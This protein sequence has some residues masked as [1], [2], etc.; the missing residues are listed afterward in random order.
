MTL[1][2]SILKH[3][4]FVAKPYPDPLHGWAV[5]TFGHG[6]TFI[7]EAESKAIVAN[8]IYTSK[9]ALANAYGFFVQLPEGVQ[10]VLVEMAYQMGVNGVLSFKNMWQALK[11]RDLNAAAT[12]M[13]DSK[14]HQQT[15]KRAQTLADKMRSHQ[16]TIGGLS[17]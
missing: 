17:E 14:W 11:Q 10:D 1:L 7:T 16:A 2:E 12:A 5:P 13:L 6:L 4:G 8:R 9:Q 3:E 15:P